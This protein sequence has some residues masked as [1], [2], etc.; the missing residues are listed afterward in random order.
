MRA[1][2]ISPLL[3]MPA[4]GTEQGFCVSER[5][6]PV[7]VLWGKRIGLIANIISVYIV[8]M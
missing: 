5:I 3:P 2:C 4:R 1:V 6:S 7:I 8:Q